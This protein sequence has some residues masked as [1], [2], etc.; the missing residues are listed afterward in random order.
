[1]YSGK[2]KQSKDYGRKS[3]SSDYGRKRYGIARI[4]EGRSIL[5]VTGG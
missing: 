5:C 2:K 4:G 1:L 3:D